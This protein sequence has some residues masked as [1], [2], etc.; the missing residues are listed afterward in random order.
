M[1]AI[2]GSASRTARRGKVVVQTYRGYGTAEHIV[3]IGRVLR[4]ASP[5]LPHAIGFWQSLKVIWRLMRAWGLADARL[6]ARFDG[7]ETTI[8]TDK[9]GYFHLILDLPAPP[10]SD[11]LWHQVAIRLEEPAVVETVG[12]VFIPRPGSDFVVISDIDDTVM[13]TGVANKLFMMWRLFVQRA[14]SRTAIPGMASLLRALHIG[15]NGDGANPMLYVSRAPW[16]IYGVL[17]RF[18]NLHG[19]PEG[20]ILFLREWGLTLQ[21]PVPRRGKGHKHNH[22]R[23]AIEHYHDLPFILIG[24]SGQRDPE[25]YAEIVKSFPD[26]VRAIYIRDVGNTKA[27]GRVIN[28]IA[29]ELERL[30]SSLILA[31]DI[32]DMA[33]HAVEQGLIQASALDDIERELD[34]SASRAADG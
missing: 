14:E 30:G 26:R 1:R 7:I 20:P 22:I 31:A 6:I 29:A 25:V 27:R 15:P 2:V 13:H 19:I 23:Q 34:Q 5:E 17:E 21:H 28:E 8:R 3:L 11:R 32:R 12:D 10:R 33:A 9:D 16:A 4:E 18:F 24:D